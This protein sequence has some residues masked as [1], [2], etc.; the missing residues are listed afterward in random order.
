MPKMDGLGQALDEAGDGDLVAPSSQAGRNRPVPGAAACANSLSI[1]RLSRLI[2]RR[3]AAAHDGQHA[4]FGTGLAA[5]H[6]RIDEAE[7]SLLSPRRGAR[8]PHLAEAVVWSTNTAPRFM[9]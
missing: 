6:G 4:V 9:P 2:I 3:L 8:A 1:S 7:A 5:R